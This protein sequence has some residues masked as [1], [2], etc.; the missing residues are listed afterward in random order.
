LNR[1]KR[2]PLKEQGKHFFIFPAIIWLLVFTIFPLL[3]TLYLSFHGSRFLRVTKFVGLENYIYVLSDYRFWNAFRVTITFV[4]LSVLLTVGLGLLLAL[5]FNRQMKGVQF[6]RT[7][8]T[9]PLFTAPVALGYMFMIILYEE[10]G[11]V[12]NFL[13]ALGANTI[14]WLSHPRWALVSVLIA[15]V[16]QWTPF[17]FLVLLAALQAAP[18]DLYEAASLDSASGWEIFRHITLPLIS[19]TLGTVVILR[20]VEAFKVFDLPFALTNGGPGLAT[21][22]LT[23]NVYTSGLR[24]QNLGVATATAVI[25]LL[26]VLAVSQIFFRRY[27]S[28]YD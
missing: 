28:N 26:M 1:G 7:I 21:R 10:G 27:G 13:H 23:F 14:P 9:T 11:P 19:P 25:L 15:D 18:R 17:A 20:T 4:V 12:N 2:V 6:F 3:Y 8:C 24:D 5:L 16:W 22:T